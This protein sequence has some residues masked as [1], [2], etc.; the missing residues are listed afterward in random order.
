MFALLEK[1]TE[2][3]GNIVDARRSSIESNPILDALEK[4]EID[5]DKFGN[6]IMPT[7]VMPPA[8]H[9]KIKGKL[10]DWANNPEMEKRW[11]EIIGKKKKQ[12]LDR[13]NSRKLVD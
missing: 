8:E 11:K 12:W 10:K 13:E 3:T 1:V 6:P 5:F 9:N 7:I 2:R 4:I